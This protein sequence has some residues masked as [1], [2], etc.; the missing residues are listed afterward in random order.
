MICI[1]GVPKTGK[2]TLCTM[3]DSA[4]IHCRS[5]D[6]IAQSLGC[7]VDGVVD[8]ESLATR[9][10]KERVVESH[11]AHLMDCEYVIIL[12]GE[13]SVLRARMLEAGYPPDKV[14]ENLDAQ[15]SEVIYSETIEQLPSNRVFYLDLGNLG[16]DDAFSILR[17][18]IIA[19]EGLNPE[20][21]DKAKQSG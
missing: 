2:T 16:L 10:N 18:K 1:S 15:R 6:S 21:G 11:Y 3:L 5:L 9:M 17:N 20:E 19:M 7:L 12:K 4:G 14:D 13:E 8:V